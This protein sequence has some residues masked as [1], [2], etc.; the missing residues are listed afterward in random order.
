MSSIFGIGSGTLHIS[1]ATATQSV[2]SKQNDSSSD[3]DA[4]LQ[5]LSSANSGS[6]AAT[7]SSKVVQFA[8]KLKKTQGQRP[9]EIKS[10]LT[11]AAT[12]LRDAAKTATGDEGK[13]LNTL[14][15]K[16]DKAAAGD[17]S[18]LQPPDPSKFAGKSGASPYA[19]SSSSTSDSLLDSLTKSASKSSSAKTQRH[20]PQISE[21]AKKTLDAVFS[22]FYDAKSTSSTGSASS[23]ST[24][25]KTSG[26]AA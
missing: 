10:T 16:F 2:S 13:F 12:K 25:A 1:S 20:A 23:S 17:D 3:T 8:S 9:G 24:S 15:D 4:L 19:N 26:A 14:A 5:S 6:P 11:E 22:L 21:N 18:A 7:D